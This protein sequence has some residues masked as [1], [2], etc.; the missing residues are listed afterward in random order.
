MTCW[1]FCRKH[2]TFLIKGQYIQGVKTF[3]TT[4]RSVIISFLL[5]LPNTLIGQYEDVQ[6]NAWL[7]VFGTPLNSNQQVIEIEERRYV[8]TDQ[9]V[10]LRIDKTDNYLTSEGPKDRVSGFLFYNN[11]GTK[12]LS[13]YY[14]LENIQHTRRQTNPPLSL[15]LGTSNEDFISLNKAVSLHTDTMGNAHFEVQHLPGFEN[16]EFK[17]Y[18]SHNILVLIELYWRS[19]VNG[20]IEF[21]IPS[22]MDKYQLANAFDDLYQT[23]EIINQDLIQDYLIGIMNKHLHRQEIEGIPTANKAVRKSEPLNT[24]TNVFCTDNLSYPLTFYYKFEH[25]ITSYLD[26][27]VLQRDHSLF[28]TFA[29]YKKTSNRFDDTR[30]KGAKI[31]AHVSD[32]SDYVKS[33]QWPVFQLYSMKGTNEVVFMVHGTNI[34][35]AG[36]LL[37]QA[38]IGGDGWL[39]YIEH[40]ESEKRSQALIAYL[41]KNGGVEI[42]NSRY[43]LEYDCKPLGMS[44]LWLP[45]EY[46]QLEPE[47]KLKKVIFYSE[48]HPKNKG[49][50]TY[51]LP[52]GLTFEDSK[53]NILSKGGKESP[54]DPL[55]YE[56]IYHN[57]ISCRAIFNDSNKIESWILEPVKYSEKGWKTMI[58]NLNVKPFNLEGT[59]G[60]RSPAEERYGLSY[61]N[62]CASQ[63]TIVHLSKEEYL[64]NYY[65]MSGDIP[66]YL[67]GDSAA[68]ILNLIG[69]PTVG[70]PAE[71]ALSKI[72]LAEINGTGVVDL[73]D[74]EIWHYEDIHFEGVRYVRKIAFILE[75]LRYH[76]FG[77]EFK[78]SKKRVMKLLGVIGKYEGQVI[79]HEFNGFQL[80]LKFDTKKDRLYAV[81]VSRIVKAE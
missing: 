81:E 75:G 7:K 29:K 70:L 48:H 38:P 31:F 25:L 5:I 14:G 34:D 45:D 64:A 60:F 49:A 22:D 44:L 2:E 8:K 79:N 77:L 66:A 56:I 72:G 19:A 13:K 9:N 78:M 41:N 27:C 26:K 23:N 69:K 37:K 35:S 57:N 52:F 6:G 1:L 3:R 15:E 33:N 30:A 54:H 16:L 63:D 10:I 76:P 71:L 20:H 73:G 61:Q 53:K 51:K 18:F 40:D 39:S 50:Y 12:L 47:R 43:T 46:N 42:E 62:V 21:N 32:G 28:T 58:S 59:T 24:I 36:N 55:I 17:V 68:H 4:Y 11:Q 80:R 65:D 67:K 74:I